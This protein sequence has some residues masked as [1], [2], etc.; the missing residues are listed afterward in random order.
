MYLKQTLRNASFA[1]QK[2]LV[3]L[4]ITVLLIQELALPPLTQKEET[5]D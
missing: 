4:Q 2:L 5:E 1:G 3:L